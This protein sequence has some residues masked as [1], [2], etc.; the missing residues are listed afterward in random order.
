M[1]AV[2]ASAS[3]PAW[4]A[5]LDGL[6][7]SRRPAYERSRQPER[8]RAVRIAAQ[9]AHQPRRGGAGPA[10]Q[11]AGGMR[12]VAVAVASAMSPRSASSVPS[13]ACRRRTRAYSFGVMPTWSRK[14]ACKVRRP[15]PSCRASAAMR[16]SPSAASSR[17][18][19]RSTSGS[20]TKPAQR[21]RSSV[22]S[23][24]GEPVSMAA[25]AA[26]R[27]SSANAVSSVCRSGAWSRN[28]A[29]RAPAISPLHAGASRR[30]R[31]STGP[32]ACRRIGPSCCAAKHSGWSARTAPS[33]PWKRNGI[34]NSASSS[35][36]PS[37]Q[38]VWMASSGASSRSSHRHCT[39]R[40]SSGGTGCSA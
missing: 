1:R 28:P 27:K 35:Q 26:A 38:M 17:A 29:S 24:S 33:A 15:T 37:G 39:W 34:P 21:A 25:C 10:L 12:L 5:A 18:T 22:H 3:L 6:S 20:G 4:L 7:V 23:A 16:R 32:A 31:H 14:R 11:V 13:S 19:A 9:G 2:H 30:P 36:R 8:I 40:R